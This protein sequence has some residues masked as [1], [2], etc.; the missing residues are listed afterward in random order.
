MSSFWTGFLVGVASSIVAG[1]LL[2]PVRDALTALFSAVYYRLSPAAERLDGTWRSCFKEP[3]PTGERKETNET[4]KVQQFGTR[5]RGVGTVGGDFPREFH[6]RGWVF[7]N[8]L[9]GFFYNSKARHGAVAERGVFLL[10]MASDRCSM[11][12]GYLW[13]DADTNNIQN[14]ETD[15]KR[16]DA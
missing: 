16:G 14:S 3:V 13:I 7:K 5:V 2:E 12:G 11:K 10:E 8:T 6:Y 4:I 9:F 1:L 15:W